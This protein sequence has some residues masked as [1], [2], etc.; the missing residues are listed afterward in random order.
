MTN[1]TTVALSEK[2]NLIGYKGRDAS[3]GLE[4]AR[5]HQENGEPRDAVGRGVSAHIRGALD[6]VLSYADPFGDSGSWQQVSRAVV[7]AKDN[8]VESIE[9]ADGDADKWLD[10]LMGVIEEQRAF[11]ENKD[12]RAQKRAVALIAR[13]KGAEAL[14]DDPAPAKRI[15]QLYGVAN[16]YVHS[17]CTE[18]L[19]RRLLSEVE[20]VLWTVLRPPDLSD[21]RLSALARQAD[22]SDEVVKEVKGLLASTR[23]W[24]AFLELVPTPVWLQRLNQDTRPLDPPDQSGGQWTARGA[25]VR[26]SKDHREETVKWVMEVFGR[27]KGDSGICINLAFSLLDMGPSAIAEALEIARCHLDEGMLLLGIVDAL[28][29]NVDPSSTLVKDAADLFLNTL[30][31]DREDSNP[32]LH[33]GQEDN[34]YMILLGMLADGA[35]PDNAA[36]R[37]RMLAYKLG[38]ARRHWRPSDLDC[39]VAEMLGE[40]SVEIPSDRWMFPLDYSPEAPISRLGGHDFEDFFGV[41]AVSAISACLVR[42]FQSAVQGLSAPTLLELA[43]EVP[44]PLGHRLRVW[45]LSEVDDADSE[46]LVRAIESAVVSRL[47]NCDDVALIDRVV[48]S[49]KGRDKD[50]ASY[51]GRWQ[52]ALGEPPSLSEAEQAVNSASSWEGYSWF[53]PYFWVPV[54]PDATASTWTG[55]EA[56]QLLAAELPPEGCADFDEIENES[57]RPEETVRSE[58]LQSLLTAEELGCMEPTDVAQRIASWPVTQDRWH[59]EALMIGS[60]LQELV[61]ADLSGWGDNPARIATLLRHPTYISHY[62]RAFSTLDSEHLGRVDIDGLVDTIVEVLGEPRLVEDVSSKIACPDDQT[63]DWDEARRAAIWLVRQLLVTKIGLAGRYQEVWDLLEREAKAFPRSRMLADDMEAS[64]LALMLDSDGQDRH[65]EDPRHLAINQQN[66]QALDTALLLAV[67]EHRTNSQVKPQIPALIKWCLAIPGGEGAKYRAIIAPRVDFFLHALPDWLEENKDDLFGN[68]VLGRIALD[69]VLRSARPYEWICTNYR[70]GVYDAAR[71]G[72]DRS[73]D[74]VLIA[75]LNGTEGYEPESVI[76]RLD[77]RVPEACGVLVRLLDYPSTDEDTSDDR[78]D[79]FFELLLKGKQYV[80]SLGWLARVDTMPHDKWT[81]LTLRTMEVTGGEIDLPNQIIRRVFDN[82]PTEES[83]RILTRLIEVQC[84]PAHSLSAEA[85]EDNSGHVNRAIWN[86]IT[87]A[88]E[89]SRWLE[90]YQPTDGSS[91]AFLQLR[92]TLRRHGLLKDPSSR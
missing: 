5:W 49:N 25:V 32:T 57:Q 88:D 2:L 46:D 30:V 80:R 87:I 84:N 86:R 65:E 89:V 56:F 43:A 42:I 82:D 8:Y 60:M 77:V 75:M 64:S 1:D 28:R 15:A 29:D 33:G 62:L 91:D 23:D 37:I 36:D 50:V 24:E 38:I 11:H 35:T 12:S 78:A 34:D 9:S 18:D 26:L 17:G 59:R 21:A 66:T 7:R 54:L 72:V 76:E 52:A 55:S 53:C 22:P 10:E 40:E 3:R 27:H 51:V 16:R 71:R 48:S 90:R 70:N 61:K 39:M 4:A 73:L 58:P 14:V 81:D 74:W 41:K 69:Q 63:R 6:A 44:E 45:A 19:S 68:D 83:F 79:R 67:H 92:E 20:D 85:N 31:R 47:P 13:L